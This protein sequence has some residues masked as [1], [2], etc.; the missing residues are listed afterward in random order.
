MTPSATAR[1]LAS[2]GTAPT[3]HDLVDVHGFAEDITA[4]RREVR[5][6]LGAEDLQ[7]L[8]RFELRGRLC[9]LLGYATAWIVP[10]PISAYLISHGIFNRWVVA[11]HVMHRGYDKVP[12]VP[13]R[14]TSSGFARG[15]RRFVDWFDWMLPEAWAHE[16]N[17]LH[18][19]HTGEV[20]DP[21]LV[22]RNMASLRRSKLSMVWRYL[23]VAYF[24]VTWKLTYYAPSTLRCLQNERLRKQDRA[25]DENTNL[26]ALF[27]PR[28]ADGR[29]LWRRCILPYALFRFLAL[30]AVF[31]A[32]SPWAA[33]SVLLTS[34]LAEMMTNLHSFLVIGPNHTGSD[35][36]SFD[37]PIVDKR[38]FYARQVLGSVNYDL[39]SEGVDWMHGFL[40]Y[41]I[42]HHLLPDLP[43]RQYREIQPRVRAMCQARGLP[44]VQQPVMRRARMLL[45]VM[46]GK[47]SMMRVA[48]VDALPAC[49]PVEDGR[50]GA[51]PSPRSEPGHVLGAS[52]RA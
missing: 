30:P 39:G 18:H 21:D 25:A 34:I 42:E 46:V 36:Y 41:Q 8:R 10:N 13:A 32:L 52:A 28:R 16:H 44:Y 2:P 33:L 26:Y 50:P 51:E 43:M 4:L 49:R 9:T 7:H 19:Y 5:A 15:W 37:R 17:V 20:H 14:Y 35:L 24:A 48:R 45:E 47:A 6:S 38:E 3:G 27:D 1:T 31:L 29:E 22:Q 40:N 12:G 23:V 11:H